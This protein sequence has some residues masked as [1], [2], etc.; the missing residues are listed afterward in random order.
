ME[1]AGITDANISAADLCEALKAAMVEIEVP[2]LTG[3]MTW[4][5]D[6]E[7]SKTPKA[8]VIADGAYKAM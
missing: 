7:P 4:T 1:K 6:G 2:G 5:A 3:T 8:M